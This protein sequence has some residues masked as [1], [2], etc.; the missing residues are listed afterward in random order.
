MAGHGLFDGSPDFFGRHDNGLRQTAHEVPTADLRVQLLL[1][2]V[3]RAQ[4]DL[5]LLCRALAEGQAELLLHEC[6]DRL[7]ELVAPDAHR[8]ARHD[9]AQTK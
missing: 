2:L 8:L 1:Q 9:A 7:V 3:G 4:G 5:D 6:D